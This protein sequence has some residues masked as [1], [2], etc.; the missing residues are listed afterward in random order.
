[1]KAAL[2]VLKGIHKIP[3]D[4]MK[5]L[6]LGFV[7]TVEFYLIPII[8]ASLRQPIIIA[9]LQQPESFTQLEHNMEDGGSGRTKM[10]TKIILMNWAFNLDTIVWMIG[11]M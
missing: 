9:S 8:I 2:L 5:R 3:V 1:M 10:R 4:I 7:Y 11:T 6:F